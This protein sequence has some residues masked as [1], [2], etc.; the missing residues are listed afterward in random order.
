MYTFV[1]IPTKLY[2]KQRAGED[3]SAMGTQELHMRITM[4]RGGNKHHEREKKQRTNQ[5]SLWAT[6]LL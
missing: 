6:I 4:K 5:S 3:N 2:Y 1:G